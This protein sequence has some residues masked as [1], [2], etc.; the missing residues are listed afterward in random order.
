LQQGRRNLTIVVKANV[1]GKVEKFSTD[2][3]REA[4]RHFMEKVRDPKVDKVILLRQGEMA[5]SYIAQ[6]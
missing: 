4:T 5:K 3:P 6:G 2:C 1:S